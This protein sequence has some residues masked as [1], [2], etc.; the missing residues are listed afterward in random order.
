MQK[1]KKYNCKIKV[2]ADRFVTWHAV[3]DL[4]RMVKSL[5]KHYPDW[6]YF[7]VYDKHTGE[8]LANYTKNK[9]P[10]NRQL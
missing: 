8:Q 10:V 3:N 7:N 5:D 2:S 9:P 1:T 6:R 4:L